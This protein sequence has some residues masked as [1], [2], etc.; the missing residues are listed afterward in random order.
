MVRIDREKLK[1]IKKMCILEENKICDNCCEC[2]IC[3][4]DPTKS[5]DNCAKC[6][7][8]A[9]FNLIELD[10]ILLYN[11]NIFKYNKGEKKRK[12]NNSISKK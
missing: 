7:E 10:D 1:Q 3:E 12:N 8:L 9:D 5:C 2:F 4:L 6:L 11:E